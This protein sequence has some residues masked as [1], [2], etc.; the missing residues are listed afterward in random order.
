MTL[1]ARASVASVRSDRYALPSYC[2]EA[3]HVA[4]ALVREQEV[5]D[6]GDE[7]GVAERPQVHRDELAEHL[8]RAQRAIERREVLARHLGVAHPVEQA[9]VDELAPARGRRCAP[10]RSTRARGRAS[11]CAARRRTPSTAWRRAAPPRRA[12]TRRRSSTS[13]RVGADVAPGGARARRRGRVVVDHDV[14]AVPGRQRVVARLGLAVDERD[15]SNSSGS[16]RS[17]GASGILS[18]STMARFCARPTIPPV[19]Q[20]HRRAQL[21][22]EQAP[23]AER[24]RERVGI[25]VVVH[26]DEGGPASGAGRPARGRR[27][28]EGSAEVR[29]V[30]PSLRRSTAP[31]GCGDCRRSRRP[32][33]R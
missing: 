19:R 33:S 9:M 11:P 28:S 4:R 20:R 18:V 22:L 24:R 6:L 1:P 23:E 5:G 10:P 14:D 7:I 26:V 30:G 15:E 21:V 16:T 17:T 3:E 32:P 2:A 31:A 12:G 29:P 25:G 27:R 13:R 8:R